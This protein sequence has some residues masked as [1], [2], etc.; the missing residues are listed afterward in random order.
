VS[1]VC[2]TLAELLA[3]KEAFKMG[4]DE[5]LA[6]I[7]KT[8]KPANKGNINAYLAG[9]KKKGFIS[10]HSWLNGALYLVRIVGSGQMVRAR[11]DLNKMEIDYI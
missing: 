6:G 7:K 11:V 4:F 1:L 3:R 9:I 2:F 8:T 10:G 5:I